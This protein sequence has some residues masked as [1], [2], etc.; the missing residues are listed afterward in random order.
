MDVVRDKVYEA[1]RGQIMKTFQCQ[2][3][4]WNPILEA[5]KDLNSGS[6]MNR[7]V[8]FDDNSR[9]IMENRLEMSQGGQL[10]DYQNLPVV[11]W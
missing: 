8:F 10:G 7:V 1:G 9:F 3:N 4:C 6:N 2:L 5:V 11:P